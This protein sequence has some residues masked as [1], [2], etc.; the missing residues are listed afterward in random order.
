MYQVKKTRLSDQIIDA[1]KKFILEE[2]FKVGDKFYSENQLTQKLNV[3]RS[4]VREAVRMLEVKGLVTVKQ[5]KGIYITD[6]HGDSYEA[7]REW[8]RNNESALCEH[9]EV[10]LMIDPKA[11]GCSAEKAEEAEIKEMENILERFISYSK[12]KNMTNL[13]KADEEFHKVLAKSTKNR[14]LYM[15]MKTMTES[16]SEGWITSL[17]IPGRIE[18]TIIEHRNIIEAIK[19]RNVENAENAM[20]THIDNALHDI[21]ESIRTS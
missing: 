10:R 7:F 4:S 21:K 11:A 16:L 5:G 6:V 17:N 9:F 14:T 18:K 19:S 12:I 1:I 3:S 8:M 20:R 13:I 15:L 2:N